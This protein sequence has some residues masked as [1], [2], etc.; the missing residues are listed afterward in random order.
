MV[1]KQRAMDEEL[2][3]ERLRAEAEKVANCDNC[4]LLTNRMNMIV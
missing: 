1:E 3:S 2:W 4:A